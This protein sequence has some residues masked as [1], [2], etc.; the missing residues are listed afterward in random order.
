M[1]SFNRNLR[2]R[3]SPWWG[4]NLQKKMQQQLVGR[5]KIKGSCPNDRKRKN[6]LTMIKCPTF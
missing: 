4:K 1:N 6:E 5:W 2:V 3:G